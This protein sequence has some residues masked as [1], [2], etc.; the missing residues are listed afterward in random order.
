MLGGSICPEC[1]QAAA[2]SPAFASS[3]LFAIC[4]APFPAPCPA[5]SGSASHSPPPK[6]FPSSSSRVQQAV[7]SA[8]ISAAVCV[9]VASPAAV[10]G[11]GCHNG[12]QVLFPSP[13]GLRRQWGHHGVYR[14]TGRHVLLRLL[15][16][17]SLA[18]FY[19]A[20]I[21]YFPLPLHPLPLPP[22]NLFFQFSPISLPFIPRLEVAGLGSVAA[23]PRPAV[24]G[25]PFLP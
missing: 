20:L 5:S 6:S 12:Q 16:L 17:P 24:A 2:P 10:G 9:V 1:G 19:H 23:L 22:L 4:D 11:V 21:T 25:V 13:S 18:L 8:H 3:V 15:S 7:Q 14:N